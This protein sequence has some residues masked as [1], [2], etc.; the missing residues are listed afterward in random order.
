MKSRRRRNNMETLFGVSEIPCD[1]TIR[2][3][4]DGIAPEALSGVFMENLRTAE[5]AGA[6]KEQR[7][8]G[9]GNKWRGRMNILSNCFF[10]LPSP[11]LQGNLYAPAPVSRVKSGLKEGGISCK[12]LTVE[13]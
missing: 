13:A 4:M 7:V 5:D 6:L 3:L 2:E 12:N 8:S 1:N 11:P 10:N 9:G